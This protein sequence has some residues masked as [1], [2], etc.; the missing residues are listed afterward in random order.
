LDI[1]LLPDQHV[2]AER[3]LRRALDLHGGAVIGKIP[4][5]GSYLKTMGCRSGKWWGLAID[6]VADVDYRGMV[7][8]EA[9]DVIRR[10]IVRDGVCV[11]DE[12]DAALGALAKELLN[13]LSTEPRYLEQARTIW[14][15]RG[16]ECLEALGRFS[17]DLKCRVAILLNDS[18]PTRDQL[19]IL[20]EA[21]RRDLKGIHRPLDWLAIRSRDFISRS[22][23]IFRRPGSL[24]VLSSR[25]PAIALALTKELLPV[26]MRAFHKR[27]L[28]AYGEP[29]KLEEVSSLTLSNE[30]V[31]P[32][33]SQSDVGI[34]GLINKYFVCYFSR[35]YPK[36]LGKPNLIC[37]IGYLEEAPSVH[38]LRF[39]KFLGPLFP[40]PDLTVRL[41]LETK[42]REEMITNQTFKNTV[43]VIPKTD[44]SNK[45]GFDPNDVLEYILKTLSCRF[46]R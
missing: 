4:A 5:R 26:L 11:A 8:I 14:Q 7:Y 34:L 39:W 9:A 41:C 13:N 28:I 3:A 46:P 20:G 18:N 17:R 27:V 2:A 30:A 10:A 36:M 40:N 37:S 45:V 25:D 6:L 23:R 42:E 29:E 16:D 43:V 1:L 33:T 12:A 24:I 15:E 21:M 35:A 19:R 31:E 22:L 44:S 38:K 32:P